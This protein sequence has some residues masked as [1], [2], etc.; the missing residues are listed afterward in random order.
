MCVCLLGNLLNRNIAVKVQTQTEV[1]ETLLTLLPV[2]SEQQ[3]ELKSGGMRGGGG[4][5]QPYSTSLH[6]VLLHSPR[7]QQST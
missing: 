4:N 6:S 1:I 3:E 7:H 5:K 2:S